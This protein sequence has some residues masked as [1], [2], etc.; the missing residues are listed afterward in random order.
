MFLLAVTFALVV[1]ACSSPPD[2]AMQQQNDGIVAARQVPLDVA[3]PER[4]K[5]GHLRYRGG[6]A[7]R[8]TDKRF[9]GLSGLLVAQDGSDFIAVSDNGY[10]IGATLIHDADG[11]L[12]GISDATI[13][14]MPGLDGAPLRSAEERDA[15]A[16]A[17]A[18]GGGVIVAFERDHR[19]WRY[20]EPGALPVAV[21]APAELDRQPSNAGMEALT[22]LGD[23]RLLA[24]SEGLVTQGGLAGWVQDDAG[25]W[26]RLTWRAGGDFQPTG[27]VTLPDGDVLVLERRYPPVGARFR[28]IAAASITPGAILDG[29]E[30]AR[31][32]GSITVDNMEAIDTRLAADGTILV[33]VVSD[34]NYSPLQTSLLM[35]F[36]LLD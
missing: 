17:R 32:E 24:F 29:T 9:G 7:L 8:S 27:A 19:L 30:I 1:A 6:L 33:Y 11:N 15:E 18:A 23:G 31:L 16:L 13:T 22:T 28:R 3:A 20:D 12:V 10:W 25:H 2:G 4:D 35:M 5:V 36:E 14:P 34:D 26:Q 21:D